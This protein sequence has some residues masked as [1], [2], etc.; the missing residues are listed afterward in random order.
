MPLAGRPC[1]SQTVCEA[2]RL[3]LYNI[4]QTPLN[5]GNE[6]ATR[7]CQGQAAIGVYIGC[8]V[9]R[10]LVFPYPI[11]MIRSLCFSIGDP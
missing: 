7:F 10:D 4:S 8:C 9:S 5:K 6:T 1:V 3:S 2:L 11:P